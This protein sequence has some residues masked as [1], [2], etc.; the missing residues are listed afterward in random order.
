MEE[1]TSDGG[2]QMRP[3]KPDTFKETRYLQCNGDIAP[4][5]DFVA[6]VQGGEVLT[7]LAVAAVLAPTCRRRT[8]EVAS[9]GGQK[10]GQVLRRVSMCHTSYPSSCTLSRDQVKAP[11]Q[12]VVALRHKRFWF[13][14]TELTASHVFPADGSKTPYS[15]GLHRTGTSQTIRETSPPMR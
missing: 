1:A 9:P 10:G 6:Q 11:Q 5:V 14:A 4:G 12:V 7:P 3:R 8:I 15:S 2:N 13:W